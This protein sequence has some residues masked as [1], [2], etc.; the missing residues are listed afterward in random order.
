MAPEDFAAVAI[1]QTAAADAEAVAS[2]NAFACGRF[3]EYFQRMAD[4]AKKRLEKSD[5]QPDADRGDNG[6]GSG[7][8]AGDGDSGGG[9]GA[10]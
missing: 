1:A 2:A 3:E 10:T 5:G 7:D 6:E 9:S 8:V 4:E